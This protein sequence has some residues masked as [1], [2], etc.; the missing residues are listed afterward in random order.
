MEPIIK[1]K[2]MHATN[3]EIMKKTR[4]VLHNKVDGEKIK[5]S[6]LRRKHVSVFLDS[7]R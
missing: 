4:M 3:A 5:A 6:N 2:L 1:T 7:N